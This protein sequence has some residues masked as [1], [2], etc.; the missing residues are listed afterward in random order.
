M[1]LARNENVLHGELDR[2]VQ[3]TENNKLVINKSKSFLMQK[4]RS[5]KYDFP[6]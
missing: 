4:S 6:P 2:F 3:F 1:I 5:R